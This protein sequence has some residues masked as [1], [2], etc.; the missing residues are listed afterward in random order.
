MSPLDA[1][2]TAFGVLSAASVAGLSSPSYPFSPDPAI[3]VMMPVGRSTRRI[4]SL[5]ESAMSK[6]LSGAMATPSGVSSW[7]SVASPSSPEKPVPRSLFPTTVVM[8]RLPASI[9]RMTSLFE[10]AK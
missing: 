6:S 8:I 2:A 10:S 9:R 7:A 1:A 4:R 5:C 3:V